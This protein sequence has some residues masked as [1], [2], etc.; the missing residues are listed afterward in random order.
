MSFHLCIERLNQLIVWLRIQVRESEIFIPVA[1]R[2]AI[3]GCLSVHDG[4][5]FRSESR[6]DIIID[7]ESKLYKLWLI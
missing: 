1:T 5:Y 7:I 2:H 4:L 6:L 3:E